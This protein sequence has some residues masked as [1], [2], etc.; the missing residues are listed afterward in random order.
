[1]PPAAFPFRLLVSADRVVARNLLLGPA[2]RRA[3]GMAT[4]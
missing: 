3:L 1:V 4:R 2:R